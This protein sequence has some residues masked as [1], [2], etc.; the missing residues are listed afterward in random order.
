ML[1]GVHLLLQLLIP[2]RF[3][4]YPGSVNWTEQGF[5]FAWRVLLIEKAGEV[6]YRVVV[7]QTGQRF[8]EYP[9][10]SLSKLQYRMLSTQPDMIHQYA[11]HIAQQYESRG[12]ADVSVYAD[13]W[14]SLNGRQS[15]RLIDETVDLARVPRSLLPSRFILPE[16]AP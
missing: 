6:E 13:A 2:L 9:R 1:A 5:R 10:R 3:A 11:R 7:P 15:Q 4:L 8:T 12:F 14:V 16:N